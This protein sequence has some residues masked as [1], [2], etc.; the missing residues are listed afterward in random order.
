MEIP[1]AIVTLSPRALGEWGHDRAH[2]AMRSCYFV[3]AIAK[4]FFRFAT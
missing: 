4:S 2:R 3:S 1:A